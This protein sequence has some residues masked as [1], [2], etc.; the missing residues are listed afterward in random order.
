MS[1]QGKALPLSIT[2]PRAL[3]ADYCWANFFQS[4]NKMIEGSFAGRHCLSASWVGST[5]LSH[6]PS[7]QKHC[8]T[9][10]LQLDVATRSD[11]FSGTLEI[12]R[13]LS[14]IVSE[15]V[16]S[17]TGEHVQSIPKITRFGASI[18]RGMTLTCTPRHSRSP[19]ASDPAAGCAAM[20]ALV[21]LLACQRSGLAQTCGWHSLTATGPSP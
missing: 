9:R 16:T 15:D 6:P 5:C 1:S 19:L 4:K 13:G 3:W 18:L 21:W 20:Q 2:L 8:N 7:A 17:Y 11:E 12:R 10:V 14:C